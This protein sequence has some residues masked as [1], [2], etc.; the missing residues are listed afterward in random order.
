MTQ[1]IFDTVLH[2][3]LFVFWHKSAV[4]IT[5]ADWAE[6]FFMVAY[7]STKLIPN[8]K[9]RCPG[10]HPHNE[11]ELGHSLT[12]EMVRH[13]TSLC[14]CF[15]S[16]WHSLVMELTPGSQ[17]ALQVN[18]V[19][20]KDDFQEAPDIHL[21]A[22]KLPCFLVTYVVRKHTCKRINFPFRNLLFCFA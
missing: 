16:L 4:F 2:H 11:V 1:S 19:P 9:Y 12:W 13:P 10:A 20:L 14:S 18:V 17:W 22:V 8:M 3:L 5:A 21:E 15:A 6:G 7:A